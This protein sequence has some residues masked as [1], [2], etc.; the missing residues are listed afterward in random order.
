MSTHEIKTNVLGFPR[1][2]QDRQLK[3]ATESYW[4]GEISLEDLKQAGARIRKDNWLKMKQAGIDYIPSNDFSFYD[5]MLDMSC[6]LGNVPQ[7]FGWDGKTINLDTVFFM[8]RGLRPGSTAKP[9]TACEMTK[10]FDTNYHYI[11]PEFSA[12]TKFTV[13]ATKVFDEFKEAK[14]LGVVTCPVLIGP[15][16]YLLLGKGP[17]GFDPLSLLDGLLPVYEEILKRLLKEGAA[18]VQMDEPVFALDLDS[19]RLEALK[20]TYERL[21]KTGVNL[22][23]AS[24]FGE[25]RSNLQTFAQLPVAGFHM[26]AVRGK[27]DVLPLARAIGSRQFLSVGIV[28]GRNI[29]KNDFTASLELLKQVKAVLGPRMT[30]A[31]SCSLIHTPIG[32]GHEPKLDAELKNWMAFAEEKLQELVALRGLLDGT[33]S[34]DVLAANAAAISSR[35]TSKRIHQDAV[36]RRA[37]AVQPQ[38]LN[39]KSVFRQRRA[40]QVKRLNLPLFPTTT[41]GSFPQTAEVRN[42]RAQWKKN[43]LTTQ[44]YEAALE[45]ETKK[46]VEFQHE[47]GIDML[48]HGEFERNDM[49]E[50]FGEQ[51]Q[52]FTFTSN[53]WVQSYGSRY[54]KPPIIFGDVSRPKPMTVRWSA[55]AQGLT[56]KPMKG[57]L[58]GPVTIS[59]WSFVR[60]DQPRS[61]TVKQIALAIRDEVLDLEKAGIAAIQIDEPAL[62]EGLPLRKTDWPAYLRWAVD[63]FRLSCS[64]VKDETQIHTHMCYSEFNDII[65]AIAELDADVI[66]IETSRSKM[67]LL[68]AFE[69]FRYPNEIG[70]GVYD[71]HSPRVPETSEM[72]DLLMKASRVLPAEHV[73][74]N[75]D[76]GLKTR[77][78]PEVRQALKNMVAA[79]KE[80]RTKVNVSL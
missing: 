29:W 32:L 4:K 70:P 36:I 58:T 11:V 17:A 42:L 64:A 48:V 56:Q 5:Q 7:R 72:V 39:R 50:Y 68:G 31:A 40:I 15:V 18:W 46:C 24:Y 27:N 55:F 14:E 9:T 60:D 41:I 69:N 16:T 54:V 43:A 2:G 76:C 20:K 57:M 77:G 21:S 33:A 6:L 13:S 66:S 51:L 63:A 28:D 75:P 38:D 49:V 59:Q 65:E 67:E 53:G 12:S 23:V 19:R 37:Q 79:A 10:W 45:A 71:I 74:V 3:K 78:W 80:I 35:A 22:F 1:I 44:A 62:R 8:A 34:Q 73:W 61:Q 26:D 47:I 52:G 25:L 30:V